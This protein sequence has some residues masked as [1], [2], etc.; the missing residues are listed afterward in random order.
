M[1]KNSLAFFQE[2]HCEESASFDVTSLDFAHC[3]DEVGDVLNAATKMSES[4][5]IAE[6]HE[7]GASSSKFSVLLGIFA[8]LKLL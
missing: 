5:V 8:N 6:G 4:G 2:K 3:V 1:K 7:A